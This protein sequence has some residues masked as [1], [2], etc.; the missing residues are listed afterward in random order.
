M[1]D[2]YKVHSE[3]IK[4]NKTTNNTKN[5]IIPHGGKK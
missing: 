5:D 3:H 1:E 4:R 2:D